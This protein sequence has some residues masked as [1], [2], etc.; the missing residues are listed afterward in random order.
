MT[1]PALAASDC[2]VADVAGRPAAFDQMAPACPP[3]AGAFSFCSAS[4][5]DAGA[6][7]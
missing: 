4:A 5:C 6:E 3:H 1:T 2:V 7:V